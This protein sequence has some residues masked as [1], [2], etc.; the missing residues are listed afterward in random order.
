MKTM[1]RVFTLRVNLLVAN[2][3]VGVLISQVLGLTFTKIKQGVVKMHHAADA[4]VNPVTQGN[5]AL[6][7]KKQ[8]YEID[9]IYL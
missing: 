1:Q 5:L 2:T 4:V 3:R 6:T 8:Y 7:K 9:I